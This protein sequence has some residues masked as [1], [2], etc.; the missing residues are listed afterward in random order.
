MC[1]SIHLATRDLDAYLQGFSALPH[2][3]LAPNTL[4]LGL[5]TANRN[6]VGRRV[7]GRGPELEIA[8]QLYIHYAKRELSVYSTASHF[9]F[10]LDAT[11]WTIT[12]LHSRR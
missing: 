1:S 6:S 9:R 3:E 10:A 4:D 2:M 12:P 11:I 5:V 7:A 8:L